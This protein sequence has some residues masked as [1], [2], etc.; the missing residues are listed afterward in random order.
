MINWSFL[1]EYVSHITLM[2]YL[3]YVW[4][5]NNMRKPIMPM[6][7]SSLSLCSNLSCH[8]VTTNHITLITH[9]FDNH[10]ISLTVLQSVLCTA[11][12]THNVLVM[13]E[14]KISNIKKMWGSLLSNI[15]FL[16]SK[17]CACFSYSC[18]ATSTFNESFRDKCSVA[19]ANIK[20][21]YIGS[22][23]MVSCRNIRAGKAI[24]GSSGVIYW[25]L[26]F[27]WVALL[28]TIFR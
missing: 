7:Q 3:V 23:R 6:C 11:N 9:H 27:S 5:S 2:T 8:S 10:H 21:Y 25:K 13:R 26:A 18:L 4:Y 19:G 17:N 16:G 12:W 20:R 1:F 15:K 22:K 24:H 28:T 14:G